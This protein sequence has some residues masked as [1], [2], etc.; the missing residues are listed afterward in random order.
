[1]SYNYRESAKVY[2]N[3]VT[4]E[5]HKAWS[6]AAAAYF[7]SLSGVDKRNYVD[8][9]NVYYAGLNDGSITKPV[10]LEST[11]AIVSNGQTFTVTGG[12]VTAAVADGVVTMTY[13]AS[14]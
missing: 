7:S 10:T 8:S 2:F 6:D 13:T 5:S 12:T 4:G 14:E 11:Q 9:M 3:G 1:M